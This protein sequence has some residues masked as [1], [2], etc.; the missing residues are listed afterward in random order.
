MVSVAPDDIYVEEGYTGIIEGYVQPVMGPGSFFNLLVP[1]TQKEEAIKV[2]SE[3]PI[4]VTTEPDMWHYSA[5]EK[6]KRNW[7]I[8]ALI[9][10]GII[11]VGLV[12]ALFDLIKR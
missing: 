3:L 1:A 12:I 8:C 2:I 7:K 5:N 10:L 11:A 9:I 4:E 6:T